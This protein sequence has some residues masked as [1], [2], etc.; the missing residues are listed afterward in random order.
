MIP[1]ANLVGFAGQELSRKFPHV[2]GVLTEISCGSIVEIILFIVLLTKDQ[3]YVIKAAILGSILATMV[4]C[5][6]FCFL[7]GG[8]K[9][10]E[11]TFS[12]AIGEAGSGLLLTA[13][14]VLTVPT[15]FE[16]ALDTEASPLTTEELDHKTLQI[17][18]IIS[19]LL[20]IAYFVYVWFQ[21]HTHHGIY[22]AVFKHD[23]QRDSDKQKDL[24]KPK[25][26]MTECIIALVI[27]IAL[28]SIIAIILVMQIEHVIENNHVS[29]AFM[30]LILVPLVEKFAEHLT[31]IDEAWDNQMN[32]AMS[33]VLGATLQ[34][35][36]FNA[37]LTVIVSWGLGKGLDL[38][39]DIFNLVLLILA[40]LTVGRFLQDQK[41]NYLEGFL[42]I[43]LY[44]AIAVAA[45]FY[46]NPVH[47]GGH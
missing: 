41:S 12:A 36:L 40:I 37:P 20:I 9:T 19:I 1:C 33:A 10:T 26:T 47:H 30:G 23:E 43:I 7:I 44:I 16:H 21:A 3:F 8:M 38:N 11:Q 32:F 15:V 5:L 29:D 42:L 39:F 34:T 45:F 46:P 25:Y 24:A 6:G 17:S 2:Y 28:V 14:V 13:G 18:R 4:L 35:A 27:S 31:A 22:D